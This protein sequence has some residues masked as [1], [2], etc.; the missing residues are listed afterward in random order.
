MAALQHS[1]SRVRRVLR[2]LFTNLRTDASEAHSSSM[3]VKLVLGNSNSSQIFF[4]F[5]TSRTA[6]ITCHSPEA[7][8]S[9]APLRPRPEEAPV[10]I[11]VFCAF[12]E[13]LSKIPAVIVEKD[14]TADE[15]VARCAATFSARAI[16][17]AREDKR[18]ESAA[19]ALGRATPT[20][21]AADFLPATFRRARAWSWGWEMR[22]EVAIVKL[23]VSGDSGR[24][25]SPE[26]SSTEKSAGR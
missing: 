23:G 16:P 18:R 15:G 19:E 8:H 11:T 26:R 6:K 4:I 24:T 14:L 20:V 22:R 5:W 7:I 25:G 13:M 1:T 12:F 17:F 10:M 2:K 21:R 3:I 9:T